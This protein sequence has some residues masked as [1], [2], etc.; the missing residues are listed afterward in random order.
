MNVAPSETFSFTYS[1]KQ[2][3]Q[4]EAKRCRQ[5]TSFTLSTEHLTLLKELVVLNEICKYLY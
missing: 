4:A 5:S 3:F 2:S 1:I